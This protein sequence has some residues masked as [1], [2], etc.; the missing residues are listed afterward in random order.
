M[1]IVWASRQ[2]PVEYSILTWFAQSTG[3]IYPCWPAVRCCSICG[4][5]QCK[6][7]NVLILWVHSAPRLD[8]LFSGLSLV[9][10]LMDWGI[11]VLSAAKSWHLCIYSKCFRLVKLW[12]LC[13]WQCRYV[14]ICQRASSKL[15]SSIGSVK[16]MNYFGQNLKK[17]YCLILVWFFTITTSRMFYPYLT[18][19]EKVYVEVVFR[20]IL[21]RRFDQHSVSWSCISSAVFLVT[22][23]SPLQ[24]FDRMPL[25]SWHLSWPRW[26]IVLFAIYRR[27]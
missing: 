16:N 23:T 17:I 15:T 9:K 22:W 13:V 1:K 7:T 26:N 6:G 14:W 21:R 18:C 8:I 12:L 11:V 5:L 3:S 2:R 10:I 25:V 19:L 27:V 24:T 20:C 4:C